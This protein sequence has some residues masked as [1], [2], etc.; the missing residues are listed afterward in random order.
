MY[1]QYKYS[2]FLIKVIRV[3]LLTP[4]TVKI[5]MP[6]CPL[7]NLPIGS[8]RFVNIIVFI[9]LGALVYRSLCS[10]YVLQHCS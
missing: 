9:M 5:L 1:M 7:C 3:G 4:I 6:A 8:A 10:Y 2:N